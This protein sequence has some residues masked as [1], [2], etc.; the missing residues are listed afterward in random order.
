MRLNLLTVFFITLILL[1]CRRDRPPTP[2]L[3]VVEL[4]T[5]TPQVPVGTPT[6]T[7]TLTLVPSSTPEPSATLSAVFETPV[8]TTSTPS[9]TSAPTLTPASTLT[10]MP[11]LGTVRVNEAVNGRPCPGVVNM[12][13]VITILFPGY[14]TVVRARMVIEGEDWLAVDQPLGDGWIWVYVQY[15]PEKSTQ[16]VE[17]VSNE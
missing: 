9:P 7:S 8:I 17:Y 13:P 16:A 4:E 11:N 14:E 15:D 1:G 2:T 10:S 6:W 12:C 5:L 3:T